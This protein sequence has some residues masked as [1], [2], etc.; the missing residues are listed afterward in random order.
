MNP[1]GKAYESTASISS[2]NS[3]QMVLLPARSNTEGSEFP[4]V[5]FIIPTLNSGRTLER[6]LT[7]IVAQ[8]YPSVEIIIIDGGS[9]DNTVSIAERY[10]TRIFRFKGALGAA[11][12]LGIEHASGKLIAN[13]DSDI[14]IPVEDWLQEAVRA[15]F[16]YPNASTLWV[17]NVCPPDSTT[18]QRAF[19]WYAW[20]MM[21][22]FAKRDRGFWGGGNSIFRKRMIEEVGGFNEED[23]TGED[24]HLSKKLRSRG[25][26]VVFYDNY[27]YHDTFRSLS[28]L[29]RKDIRRS[30]N[31]KQTGISQSMGLSIP[32]LLLEHTGI[33][34]D[35]AISLFT[36]RRY[37][38]VMVPII[39]TLRLLVYAI[40]YLL[41]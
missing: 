31:F 1:F 17:Y 9:T 37:F 5:S 40:V 6:C 15:L 26:R 3:P 38:F 36:E 8:R 12:Q 41:P 35:S 16:D 2:G 28:E 24:F 14:Y 13:W 34:I 10:A 39:V 11:R 30:A 19:S 20:K 29:V 21:L 33:V 22:E 32:E 27:V 25:Y 4:E 18:V 7:S 23:D